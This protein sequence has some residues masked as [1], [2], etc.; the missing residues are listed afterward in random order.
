MA[1]ARV[2]R[3]LSGLGLAILLL[4]LGG[5][6]G[7]RLHRKNL[8]Q[9][10]DHP[11][12]AAHT[13]SSALGVNKDFKYL[14]RIDGRLVFALEALQTLGTKSGWHDIQGVSLQLY[15]DEQKPGPLL[16]CEQA[17][18]N[19]KTRNARLSGNIHILFPDGSFLSTDA[20]SLDQG[21]RS[22]RT[23][24]RVIYVGK[25]V[26][27]SAGRASFQ[28]KKSLLVLSGGVMVQTASGNT[29]SA[30]RVEYQREQGILR[31][32]EG[33][34]FSYGPLQLDAGGGVVEIEGENS[35]PSALRLAGGVRIRVDD[36]L[37]GRLF[38]S[39]SET[40][41]AR[42]DAEGSWQVD[43]ASSSDWVRL[44]VVGGSRTLYQSFRSWRIRAVYGRSGLKSARS[45]GRS[46]FRMIP[47]EGPIRHGE[48]EEARLWFE[49]GEISNIEL[50]RNV[51]L[52]EESILAKALSAR[53]DTSS[54]KAILQG[55]P[56]GRPRVSLVSDQGKVQADQAMLSRD[57][58]RVELHGRVQGELNEVPLMGRSAGDPETKTEALHMAADS[59]KISR[60]PENYYEL[61][62]GAR[63]WQ[64]E[65]L[66]VGDEIL[67]RPTENYL[68]ANGHIRTTFPAEFLDPKASETEDVVLVSRLMEFSEK[69]RQAHYQ[70]QVVFTGPDHVLSASDLLIEFDP[71]EDEVRTVTASGAVEMQDLS[72]GQK[73][74]GSHIIR[75]I[76]T[77]LVE[78]E[79]SPAR[80]T[81]SRGNM[82]A[83][84]TLTFSE[85]DGSVSVSEETE[86]IYHS[87]EMNTEPKK[88]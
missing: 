6:V 13:D 39:V 25:T 15:G 61:K 36:V 78:V 82:L 60:D 40:F 50:E 1:T 68:R 67:Y 71:V 69:S 31:I 52:Y 74:N 83:G 77:G 42:R 57:Q 34:Q 17:S 87:E 81:D 43:A 29:M 66:L 33:A 88:P 49:E 65:K 22:F 18:F 14:E 10:L 62:G 70:G 28:V 12:P 80:A 35:E 3:W 59:L 44:D 75:D 26:F 56:E 54:G 51:V 55:S 7:L 2:I 21:G 86:T 48:A 73:L 58:Q 24:T 19:S 72:R 27:G 63:V 38:E 20:G 47:I 5:M 79:G 30:P 4:V 46:C 84:H 8:S 32:P 85:A 23:S 37:S 64:G 45:T 53:I 9:A 41:Q 16:T 11:I 76:K